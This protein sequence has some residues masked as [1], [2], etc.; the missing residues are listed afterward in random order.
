MDPQFFFNMLEIYV[1]VRP[2]ML[3]ILN[4]LYDQKNTLISILTK[5]NISLDL[6]LTHN[7]IITISYEKYKQN[8]IYVHTTRTDKFDNRPKCN[9]TGKNVD[10]FWMDIKANKFRQF[11]VI[12]Q[13][14]KTF[15]DDLISFLFIRQH[16]YK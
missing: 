6:T 2:L 11:N 7:K 5:E 1:D 4:Y 14:Y 15:E 8:K 9:Y 12:G 3:I 13:D 10:R 16:Q